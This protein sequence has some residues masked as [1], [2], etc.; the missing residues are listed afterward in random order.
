MKNFMQFME[1]AIIEGYIIPFEHN[2]CGFLQHQN[3]IYSSEEIFV[4]WIYCFDGENDGDDFA[5]LYLLETTDGLKG[6]LIQVYSLQETGEE[7]IFS[8]LD[9]KI[10]F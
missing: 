4:D 7:I 9:D 2:E 6:T 3:R 5:N 1:E 8:D 10:D